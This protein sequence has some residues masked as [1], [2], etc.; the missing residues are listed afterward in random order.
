MSQ[1]GTVQEIGAIRKGFQLRAGMRMGSSADT[2]AALGIPES[3]GLWCTKIPFGSPGVGYY[4]TDEGHKRKFRANYSS[5]KQIA[6]LVIR[7][8]LPKGMITRD[9]VQEVEDSKGQRPC[10]VYVAPDVTG[11][12]VYVGKAFDCKKRFEQH[13]TARRPKPGQSQSDWKYC[14]LCGEFEN[15]WVKH[16]DEV[17]VAVLG[18]FPSEPAALL[19]EQEQIDAALPIFNVVGNEGNPRANRSRP[20]PRSTRTR[21]RVL[22]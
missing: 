4:V 10:Y 21:E 17:N 9:L 19:V 8:Q 18:P 15:F 2:L 13:R 5:D 1:V 11:N 16:V 20:Q 22:R 7:K 12:V 6:D 3:E 14:S